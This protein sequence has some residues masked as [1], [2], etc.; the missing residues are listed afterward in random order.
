[1][2]LSRDRPDPSLFQTM[3]PEFCGSIACPM[4]FGEA[5]PTVYPHE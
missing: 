4:T 2:D 1:M 3:S 5:R